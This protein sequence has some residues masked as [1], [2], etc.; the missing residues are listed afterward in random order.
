MLDLLI[1]YTTSLEEVYGGYDGVEALVQSSVVTSNEAFSNSGI[2]L[3]LRLVGLRSVDYDE[4]KTNMDVDLNHL[5]L[6]DGVMDEVL[7]WRDNMGADLVYLF[8]GDNPSIDHIGSAY[9]LRETNGAPNFGFG[10]VSGQYAIS[11]LVLQHEIGHNL[12]AAHDPDNADGPGLFPYSYGHRFGPPNSPRRFRSVMAYAPGAEVNYFS[13]PDVFFDGF[14]TGAE[15]ADNARTLRQTASAIA[16]YRGSRPIKPAANAGPDC[17]VDDLDNDGR[18]V[19]QLDGSRSRSLDEIVRWRWTWS[20]GSAEG[21]TVEIQLPVGTHEV[22]LAVTNQS[23]QSHSDSVEITVDSFSPIVRTF[24]G[25]DRL[26][27]LRKNGKLYAAGRN[28]DATLGIENYGSRLTRFERVPLD[29]VVEVATAEYHTLFRLENGAVYASGSNPNGALGIGENKYFADLEKVFDSGIVSIATAFA[30]SLFVD[31]DGRVF[32]SGSDWPGVFGI[33][34]GNFYYSP[35]LIFPSDAKKAVAGS[36]FSA[37]LKKDGTLWA[38]G[39]ILRYAEPELRSSEHAKFHQIGGSGFVDIAAGQR[40][41]AAL[42]SDGSVWTTGA[43]GSGQLGS[44]NTDSEQYGFLKVLGAGARAIQSGPFATFITLQDGSIVGAGNYL[45][46]QFLLYPEDQYSFVPLFRGRATQLSSGT[47]YGAVLLKDGSLW[48]MGSNQYG[49]F[50]LGLHGDIYSSLNKISPTTNSLFENLPPTPLGKV[51]GFAIDFDGDGFAKVQFDSSQSYDDWSIASY[52]WTWPEGSSELANPEVILATGTVPITLELTD[53]NGVSASQNFT[54]EVKPLTPVSQVL[55]LENRILLIKEDGSLWG[56][57][58]NYYNAFGIDQARSRFDVFE[59]LFDEG[60]VQVA[61]GEN[62][63]LVLM[64]DGSLWGGGSNA[65]GQLGLESTGE[66]SMKQIWPSGVVEISAG[67]H[68]SIFLLEDGTAMGMGSIYSGQ[69]G[70]SQELVPRIL[71]GSDVV[72]V[73]ASDRFSALLLEDG[74]V[75]VFDSPFS[76]PRP[77]RVLVAGVSQLCSIGD[78]TLFYQKSDGSYSAITK[79]SNLITVG[80]FYFG[81]NS[82]PLKFFGEH[83]RDISASGDQVVAIDD[84]G[85]SVGTP[86]N[87]GDEYS[88]VLVAGELDEHF[89]SDVLSVSIS[90][91]Y[92]VFLLEDGSAWVAETWSGYYARHLDQVSKPTPLFKIANGSRSRENKPPIAAV[93]VPDTYYDFI[94]KGGSLVS[95]DGSPSSDD[96]SIAVWEWTW[97]DQIAYGRVSTQYFPIGDTT[98]SLLVTDY[99]GASDFTTFTVS[100]RDDQPIAALSGEV[101]VLEN[102]QAYSSH[103]TRHAADDLASVQSYFGKTIVIDKSGGV[104]VAGS[105]YHGELGLGYISSSRSP[106]TKV[107]ESGAVDAAIGASSLYVVME[108]GSLWSTENRGLVAESQYPDPS[109][110]TWARIRDSEVKQVEAYDDLVLYLEKNGS[111]WAY[112]YNNIAK[113]GPY[114]YGEL[115]PPDEPYRL[116]SSGVE[117][118]YLGAGTVLVVKKDRSL[119]GMGNSQAGELGAPGYFVEDLVKLSPGPV[120]KVAIGDKLNA[121]LLEDGSLWGIGDWIGFQGHGFEPRSLPVRGRPLL[122]ADVADFSLVGSQILALRNDGKLY[123]AGYGTFNEHLPQD[124]WSGP[125]WKPLNDK[126]NKRGVLPPIADAGPDLEIYAS[127]EWSYVIL[128]GSLSTD[129]WAIA[130]WKW[131]IDGYVSDERRVGLQISEG[132]YLV[133]LW[134]EDEFGQESFDTMTLT[135]LSGSQDQA[136]LQRYFTKDQI[137]DMLDPSHSDFDGDGFSNKDELRLDTNPNDARS[138]P[139]LSLVRKRGQAH[140]LLS[141]TSRAW[142]LKVYYSHDLETWTEVGSVRKALQGLELTDDFTVPIFFRI[143]LPAE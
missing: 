41:L 141:G 67:S 54:V 135:V 138:R 51:S 119:W 99:D 21:E 44:G 40:H 132:E 59:P 103:P 53:D 126:S 3:S 89:A 42:A 82:N 4:D 134:V 133:E 23:A 66:F 74:S 71:R 104:W 102:G 112:G 72:Q 15:Q 81:P 92:R 64:E 1:V 20:G 60:V 97:G 115:I 127:G 84:D 140:L 32:G 142:L 96:R 17:E 118:L 11:D 87:R 85:R 107:F 114:S 76:N 116:M 45:P 22:Q 110:K 57:G 105:N 27:V 7:E 136:A 9:L 33:P 24:S 121:W 78:K 123:I 48:A 29:G 129:D 34:P 94:E 69:A 98:V 49:Q 36:D 5:R 10:V 25:H 86:I 90:E 50:G 120:S 106:F 31:E 131:K 101:V 93:D 46:T 130:K 35:T 43:A 18:G 26:F 109:E 111:V 56:I 79:D 16:N 52:K 65:A 28:I 122:F 73:L 58:H 39:E 19:V 61:G 75:W 95:L 83:F 14:A 77:E 70:S 8:R 139:K 137:D 128:D 37:I 80:D 91:S 62:H 38:S 63:T 55:A 125:Y 47:D 6:R 13:G 108:D 143:G 68:N 113:L 100:V 2:D 124:E 117:E 88:K 12:G 30:F